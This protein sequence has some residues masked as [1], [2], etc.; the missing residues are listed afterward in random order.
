MSEN[1]DDSN[2]FISEIMASLKT[3]FEIDDTAQ[4]AEFL[5]T[6]R[7]S[8]LARKLDVT[9]IS[10][11]RLKVSALFRPRDIHEFD[12]AVAQIRHIGRLKA[13]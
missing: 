9:S 11:Y 2:D 6:L 10:N 8:G 3:D 1:L 5:E 4:S 12:E 13:A 7:R